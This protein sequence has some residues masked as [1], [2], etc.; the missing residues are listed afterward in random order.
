MAVGSPGDKDPIAVNEANDP[1]AVDK[2]K[3]PIVINEAKDYITR[4]RE[5]SSHSIITAFYP[6]GILPAMK[7]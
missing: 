3:D 1:I 2:S 7:I 4:E 5:N 6:S